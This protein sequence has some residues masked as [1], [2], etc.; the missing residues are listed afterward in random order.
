MEASNIPEV[1]NNYNA[2]SNGNKLI[3]VTGEVQLPDLEAITET[4]SGAGVLGEYETSIPGHYSSITQEVPFRILD[5]D[6]FSLMNPLD[7]V[8]LTF[9]ASE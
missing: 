5:T 3:G 9:R 4:I 7:P 1:I 8:D 6:I 2:Y